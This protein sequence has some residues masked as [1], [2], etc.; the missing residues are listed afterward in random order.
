MSKRVTCCDDA[1]PIVLKCSVQAGFC[2]FAKAGAEDLESL[3][4]APEPA[5]AIRL[6]DKAVAAVRNI[7]ISSPGGKISAV[8]AEFQLTPCGVNCAP[9]PLSAGPLHGNKVTVVAGSHIP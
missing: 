4:R 9:L 8:A 1:S 3:A 7:M 5:S 6:T 2:A